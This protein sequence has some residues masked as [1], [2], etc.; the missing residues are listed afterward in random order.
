[1]SGRT[2]LHNYVKQHKSLTGF[3]AWHELGTRR[4][5]FA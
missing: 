3:F 1:M 2:V 4:V 5:A